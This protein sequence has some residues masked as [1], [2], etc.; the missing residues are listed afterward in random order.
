MMRMTHGR[1]GAVFQA[2]CAS[3]VLWAQEPAAP[4]AA[5][6][7]ELVGHGDLAA[8]RAELAAVVKRGAA[9]ATVFN[10]L[11][12]VEAQA[13]NRRAAESAFE[14][15]IRLAPKAAPIYEN[16]GRLYQERAS[17]D[18]QA[19]QKAIATYRALLRFEPADAEGNFQLA[20]LLALSG[21]YAESLAHLR[22]LPADTPEGP[23]SLGV[24]CIDSAGLRD[25][26]AARDAAA[27]LLKHPDLAEADVA[28]IVPSLE[29]AG[30]RAVAIALLEG[31]PSHGLASVAT[32]RLL[33]AAY[34][35]DNELPKA[36]ETFEGAARAG[37]VTSA[38]LLDLARVAF[39]QHDLEGTLGYLAHA[40]DLEPRNS[41][42]H[43]FFAIA[44]VELN[45]PLEAEKSLK[46]AV[47]LDPSNPYYRYAMG[48]VKLQLKQYQEALPHLLAF[49]KA[50][51][52]DPNGMFM[53]GLAYFQGQQDEAAAKWLAGAAAHPRT[54]AGAHCYLGRIAARAGEED[55][56]LYEYE[57]ALAADPNYTDAW[58]ELALVR[59]NAGHYD[60]A[61]KAL[62]H[63]LSLD[64]EHYRAN[65]CLLTLYRRQH[66]V[67][68]D[69]QKAKFDR[70]REKEFENLKFLLRTV[71]TRPY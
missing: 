7:Q 49:S 5:R 61:R 48:A 59:L 15:A 37:G 38:V 9:D 60:E 64:P 68:G 51:P 65:Y 39:K 31:L 17:E 47:S 46:E 53:L 23:G 29:R 57:Q 2:L 56:A 62:D 40:R 69:E 41:G 30:G 42:I 6:I 71:E 28:S 24:R 3:A 25:E 13:H 21:K 8:A 14:K 18:P 4:L 1:A 70:L 34:E 63:A 45:L 58:A 12:V 32:L 36:R 33:A 20:R 50:K 35:T 43:F 54:A 27:R 19:M 11:G 16:L 55:R 22:R 67:H 26:P 52:E 66:D 44:S 10:L